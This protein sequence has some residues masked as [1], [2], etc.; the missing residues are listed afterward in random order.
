MNLLDAGRAGNPFTLDT[1]NSNGYDAFPEF[2]RPTHTV[3]APNFFV[4]PSQICD[5]PLIPLGSSITGVNAITG[6]PSNI[7]SLTGAAGLGAFWSANSMT[8]SNSLDRPYSLIYPRVTTQSN[9]FTVHVRAQSLQKVS[10]KVGAPTKWTE[11]TDQITGEYRG[12]F[13][14]EKYFD[15]NNATLYSPSQG[16]LSDSG[17]A[18]IPAD[19]QVQG[20]PVTVGGNTTVQSAFWRLL[21]NKRFS[22]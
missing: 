6:L 12:S 4:S 16:V 1:Y 9:T 13:T 7:T 19:A 8:G 11:G 17:D 21:Y 14:V 22:Q 2:N 5:L 10:S 18:A 3:A 15:P 20:A